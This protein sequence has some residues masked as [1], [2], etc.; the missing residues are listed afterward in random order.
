M[1]AVWHL[2]MRA[3]W[4]LRMRA[5]WH[6]RMRAVWTNLTGVPDALS[7]A[8]GS[9]VESAERAGATQESC[10]PTGHERAWNPLVAGAC[11]ADSQ[12]RTCLAD[13]QFRRG[14]CPGRARRFWARCPWG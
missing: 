7:L 6:L 3:V 13:S 11:L 10:G 14:S 12:F 1:R 5:V 4:H 2:R 8:H 9:P